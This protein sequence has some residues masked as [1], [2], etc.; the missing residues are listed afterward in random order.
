MTTYFRV[1]GPLQVE[2]CDGDRTPTAHK[3]RTVLALLLLSPNAI[4]PSDLIIEELWGGSPPASARNTLQSYVVHLRRALQ[5]DGTARIETRGYGYKLAVD[6]SDVD[7][8]QFRGHLTAAYS[9]RLRSDPRGA[10]DELVAALA[11]WR[12]RPLAGVP[13]GPALEAATSY[14]GELWLSAVERRISLDVELGLHHD[15]LGELT[16]LVR[17]HPLNENLTA[18]L[19]LALYRAGRRYVAVDAYHTLRRALADGLGLDPCP[20]LQRLH[21][22]VLTCDPVLD[23]EQDGVAAGRRTA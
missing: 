20:A 1:L 2:S 21:Q 23:R 13:L 15:V 5:P 12:G 18:Q 3:L 4:L 14:L 16:L 6:P 9:D 8:M 19:M 10:R 17:E 7:L 11:L 22:A